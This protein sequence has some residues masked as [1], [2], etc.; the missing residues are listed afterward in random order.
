MN[1]VIQ[2]SS[3]RPTPVNSIA[4]IFVWQPIVVPIVCLIMLGYVAATRTPAAPILIGATAWIGGLLQSYFWCSNTQRV[5]L[6]RSLQQIHSVSACLILTLM[7]PQ[8]S[9]VSILIILD[10][11]L[12]EMLSPL[13]TRRCLKH[14]V[15]IAT[16]L[17]AAIVD[18]AILTY[19]DIFLVP[20]LLSS[21]EISLINTVLVAPYTIDILERVWRFQLRINA[22]VTTLQQTNHQLEATQS[23]LQQ[24]LN[25]RAQLL[26]I[27]RAVGSTMDLSSLLLHMITQLR[28][29]IPY[30]RATMN[31]ARNNELVEILNIGDIPDVP[32]TIAG[33][34]RLPDHVQSLMQLTEPLVIDDA[35]RFVP[36]ISGAFLAVPFLIRGSC[37]GVLTL[38]HEQTGFYT[39]QEGDLCMAFANQVAGMINAA[40]LKEA[41]T[42]A[43]IIAERHRLARELH[44][45]VSQLLF[46]IVLGTRTALEQLHNAPAA[47]RTALEYSIHLASTALAEM[48]AL[49]FT[50]RPE[51]LQRKGL[52]SALQSQI[53]LLQSN[54]NLKITL[55]AP[56]GEPNLSLRH[57]EYLYRIAAEAIQNAIRHSRCSTIEL[58]IET[59]PYLRLEI[60]DDGC[61]FDPTADFGERLG[62]LSMHE[63]AAELGGVLII[64]SAP[65][66]GT[67][68]YAITHPAN[69]SE[70]KP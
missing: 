11:L 51:T 55:A 5:R 2:P 12:E 41:S 67:R 6:A 59:R 58:L 61:G 24:R 62:L 53:D 27:S 35:S 37:I 45:S 57:K 50:L 20:Q 4:P 44:D 40:Q 49:I 10:G 48:R 47:A 7:S 3:I 60:T 15:I 23:Q 70:T 56:H 39:Q 30:G 13:A 38:R 26:E 64:D 25:E 22:T 46:G 32:S 1:A 28:S 19:F 43:M 9:G 31:L 8:L 29:V 69:Q 21:F 17:T 68:I 42:S 14:A 34:G 66:R 33:A 18:I 16:A 65:G 54:H 52:I 36:Q 63:H